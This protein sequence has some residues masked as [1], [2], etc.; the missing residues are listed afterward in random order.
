MTANATV[1]TVNGNGNTPLVGGAYFNF[2]ATLD[3]GVVKLAYG[4][5][6][7]IQ[8]RLNGNGVALPGSANVSSTTEPGQFIAGFRWA[9]L[10]PQDMARTLIF[11]INSPTMAP[12]APRSTTYPNAQ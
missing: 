2:P 10:G 9:Y 6:G 7:P 3:Y 5:Q 12:D 8:P 1:P 4:A 11:V